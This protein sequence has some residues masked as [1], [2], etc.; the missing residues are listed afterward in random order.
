M[1]NSYMTGD[2]DH[3]ESHELRWSR[4]NNMMVAQISTSYMIGNKTD[5]DD[6][7]RGR[8]L[9]QEAHFIFCKL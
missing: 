7:A 4:R 9:E 2:K 1:A 5:H 3:G 6:G 8:T